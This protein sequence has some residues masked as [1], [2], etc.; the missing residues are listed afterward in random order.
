MNIHG[1][2]SKCSCSLS[3]SLI[4]SHFFLSLLWSVDTNTAASPSFL[5]L[6]IL[7]SPTRFYSLLSPFS[8]VGTEVIL[9]PAPGFAA[10][11][12]T[13]RE[14]GEEEEEGKE[15]VFSHNFFRVNFSVRQQFFCQLPSFHPSHLFPSFSLLF[16]SFFSLR[17]IHSHLVTIERTHRDTTWTTARTYVLLPR[18][19]SQEKGMR[20]NEESFCHHKP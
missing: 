11:L 8:L 17:L 16:P 20:K 5:F 10:L 18:R 14:E 4:L 12:R 7:L 1:S 9:F 15:E 3:L 2:F 6:S 19:R 13:R